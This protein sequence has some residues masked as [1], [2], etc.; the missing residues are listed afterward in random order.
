MG[1]AFDK[2]HRTL[3]YLL[4]QHRRL[5]FGESTQLLRSTVSVDALL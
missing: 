1:L 2:S 5:L 3:T 4:A